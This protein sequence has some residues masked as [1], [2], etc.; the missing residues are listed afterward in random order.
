VLERAMGE[1]G[2]LPRTVFADMTR[3]DVLKAV[4]AT[5]LTGAMSGLDNVARAANAG[6][7]MLL[8]GGVVLSLDPKVGDFEGPAEAPHRQGGHRDGD[9]PGRARLRPRH[10]GRLADAGQGG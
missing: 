7:R 3:R 2:K 1:V 5:A 10:E 6:G 8:K 4:G 9:H